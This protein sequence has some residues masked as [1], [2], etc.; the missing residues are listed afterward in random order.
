MKKEIIST[1]NAPSAIGPYS[2]AIKVGNLVLISGQ[3]GI[4]PDDNSILENIQEQTKQSLNNI[5]CILKEVNLGYSDIIKVKIFLKD[6]KDFNIVND[7]YRKY[8][9]GNYP[10]RSCFEIS[11]LPK[12][13]LIE[14]E[15]V[16]ITK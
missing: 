9:N 10:A 13:A 3:L 11:R 2:Q 7:I 12:D 14:I 6:L 15:V 5:G 16:A 8:F 1:S 4:N